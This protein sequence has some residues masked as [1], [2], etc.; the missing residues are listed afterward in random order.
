MLYSC[1]LT[2][3]WLLDAAILGV[4]CRLKFKKKIKKKINLSS[5]TKK[6]LAKRLVL[7]FSPA[8][9]LIYFEALKLVNTRA[10][11]QNIENIGILNIIKATR[12]PIPSKGD[13]SSEKSMYNED[14]ITNNAPS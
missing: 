3:Q 4:I 11:L 7:T 12:F 10:C 9:M 14:V 8:V 5:H 6:I 13:M 1:A 2:E